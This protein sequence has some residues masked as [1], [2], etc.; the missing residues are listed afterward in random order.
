MSIVTLVS[1]GIDSSLMAILAREEGIVQYPIFIDYGQ[2]AHDKEWAACRYVCKVYDLPEPT[3]VD[4]SG[5]GRN[6]LS[7]IT[8]R[9]RDIFQDAFLPGRNLL[10]LLVGAAFA[11]Q[12]CADAVSIGLL[13]E[14]TQ[15]FPDQT[16]AFLTQAE[17]MI[18]LAMGKRI[19]ILA[20]LRSFY[21]SDI[22]MLAQKYEV[23]GTYSCHSGMAEPCGKCV[24]C[25]EFLSA[26]A[27]E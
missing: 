16:E 26:Q 5:F 18:R 3:R 2:L 25:N 23:T 1:G 11:V 10:F 13:S 20:P 8:D 24:S 22:L 27:E 17:E 4:L 9:S 14:K 7:G 12:F 6:I 21:K 15:I 19:K